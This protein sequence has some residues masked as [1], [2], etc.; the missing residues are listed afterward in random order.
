MRQRALAHRALDLVMD[1]TDAG[2]D[3]FFPYSGHVDGFSVN[4]ERGKWEREKEDFLKKNA[5]FGRSY[6]ERPQDVVRLLEMV[7]KELS[8]EA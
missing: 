3:S 8:Y 6:G 7:K 4:V 2:H 1:L 5:Y